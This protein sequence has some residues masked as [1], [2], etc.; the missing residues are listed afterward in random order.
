MSPSVSWV[1]YFGGRVGP[2]GVSESEAHFPGTVI[3]RLS[4]NGP[5]PNNRSLSFQ[6]LKYDPS[7]TQH[8]KPSRLSLNLPPSMRWA[9]SLGRRLGWGGTAA[10]IQSCEWNSWR[11][12][13]RQRPTPSR[14]PAP[15]YRGSHLMKRGTIQ[16]KADKLASF[17]LLCWTEIFSTIGH[18]VKINRL[19]K[20]ELGKILFLNA[21]V[22][23]PVD[24]SCT[25]VQLLRLKT[26]I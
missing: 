16:F 1:T 20:R 12:W 10:G 11:F 6:G 5:R 22:S 19:F 21:R 3:Q 8:W 14:L 15:S 7:E 24:M 2:R 25:E 13:G 23:Q 26:K 9:W 17:W 18:I 4:E